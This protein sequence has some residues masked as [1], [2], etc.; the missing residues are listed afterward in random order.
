MSD[1]NQTKRVIF[2]V[3]DDEIDLESLN[4]TLGN[5]PGWNVDFHAFTGWDQCRDDI[6]VRPMDVL[7]LDYKLDPLTGLDIVRELRTE[8]DK[9]PI[10]ILTGQ[11]SE[12]I[13]SQIIKAGADDYL[14]KDE[15][16]PD[17][18]RLA[19]SNV[20]QRFETTKEKMLLEKQLLEAQKMETLG[21]LAG[22]I[23]HDFNNLLMSIM[24]YADFAKM[25][26]KGREVETDLEN[27]IKTCRQMA[28][29]VKQLLSFSRNDQDRLEVVHLGMVISDAVNI[30]KHTLP[31]HI[32]FVVK[33][34]DK[35]LFIKSNTSLLNQI[36]LNLCIN[37]SEAMPRGGAIKIKYKYIDIDSAY[38]MTHPDLTAG[39]HALIE[40]RDE[41]CGMSEETIQRIFEPFFTTKDLNS[42]K[43]TGLGLS[44][45]WSN[46][47]KLGGTVSVYSEMGN[48]T[49]FKV[50]FPS[51]EQIGPVFTPGDEEKVVGQKETILVVDDESLILDL[52]SKMLTRLN[53]E[54]Y[55]A[56]SGREAVA[57]FKRIADTVDLV[58]L[59]MS[60]PDLDGTECMKAMIEVKPDTKVMF[61]SGHDLSDRSE[62]LEALGCC[63]LVEKP[64]S[65]TQLGKQISQVLKK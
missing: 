54:V 61:A 60:M 17:T 1:V 62:E 38:L 36:I 65:M 8:G 23:A 42:I 2:A 53:Y 10:I 48:G 41:G 34:P 30:L 37:A 18:L 16:T 33:K 49:V 63:G 50:Y 13:A 21:T 55:T 3:D 14:V 39:Q 40:I 57:A 51:G 31:K 22:G 12:K 5:I 43:G 26:S 56:A 44:I 15:I 27:I 29:L 46:V 28:E 11:G 47:K 6:K 35:P 59:D 45:V 19:I 64:Y 9:R 4:R 58:I 7:F 24:G 25:K 32:E 52:V 20:M